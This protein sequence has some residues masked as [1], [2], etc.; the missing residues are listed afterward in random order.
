MLLTLVKKAVKD[1]GISTVVLAGGVASNSSLRQE[2]SLAKTLKVF[3]PSLPLCTDN[4]AMVAGLAY[5]HLRRG[6][7]SSWALN[8]ESRVPHFKAFSKH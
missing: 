3:Y 8:A 4:G 7:R 1:T 6:D 2:F 5:H